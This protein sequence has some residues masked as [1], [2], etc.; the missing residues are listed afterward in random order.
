MRRVKIMDG[1][2]IM[3][4]AHGDKPS[5][6]GTRGRCDPI[7]PAVFTRSLLHRVRRK[8]PAVRSARCSQQSD[9]NA[10]LEMHPQH[11]KPITRIITALTKQQNRSRTTK[12]LTK[13][14]PKTPNINKKITAAAAGYTHMSMIIERAGI[15]T[16]EQ[17]TREEMFSRFSTYFAALNYFSQP[18]PMH[19][20]LFFTTQSYRPEKE[21]LR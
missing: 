21:L 13:N 7:C 9:N 17:K 18:R 19:G 3:L 2:W 15:H 16:G 4:C 10:G 14:K 5:A 6:S 8:R 11:R 20:E 1:W 12:S